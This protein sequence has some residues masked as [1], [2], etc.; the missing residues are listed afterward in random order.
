MWEIISGFFSSILI[1]ISSLNPQNLISNFCTW[2]AKFLNCKSIFVKHWKYLRQFNWSLLN[3]KSTKINLSFN[4]KYLNVFLLG[5][6]FKSLST[7]LF[8]FWLLDIHHITN[9]ECL[10]DPQSSCQSDSSHWDANIWINSGFLGSGCLRKVLYVCSFK[11]RLHFSEE[12]IFVNVHD[13]VDLSQVNLIYLLRS[14]WS[15]SMFY[16]LIYL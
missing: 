1:L 6:Y 7:S 4:D 12:F 3:A 9:H 14:C 5:E 2:T 10:Q 11:H 13:L 16:I 8:S 15:S